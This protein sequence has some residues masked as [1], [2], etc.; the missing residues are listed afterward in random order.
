MGTIRT[1]MQL[2]PVRF[3]VDPKSE[4]AQRPFTHKLVV[5]ETRFR[6]PS[7]G[8]P[9]IQEMYAAL[10]ADE[11]RN[12]LILDDIIQALEQGRSPILLTER[13]DHLE[14][15]ATRLEKLARH[16]IV[17]Q[18]GVGAKEAPVGERVLRLNGGKGRSGHSRVHPSSRGRGQAVG[19]DEPGVNEKPPS[20]GSCRRS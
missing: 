20:G 6:I 1:E 18:G 7:G 10:V 19:S 8:R 5:R 15:F 3:A 11:R 12:Q 2:G 17:L 13:K 9:G 4:A 16:L 14:Y